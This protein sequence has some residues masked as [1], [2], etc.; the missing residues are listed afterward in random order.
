V[1]MVFAEHINPPP[2]RIAVGPIG[3]EA[4][5]PASRRGRAVCTGLSPFAH[6]G[7]AAHVTAHGVLEGRSAVHLLMQSNRQKRSSAIGSGAS[8]GGRGSSLQIHVWVGWAGLF[9]GLRWGAYS[10]PGRPPSPASSPEMRSLA[11][12]IGVRSVNALFSSGWLSRVWALRR[13]DAPPKTL[14][15]LT[16]IEPRV[17]LPIR[18]GSLGQPLGLLGRDRRRCWQ[19]PWPGQHRLSAVA[20][21]F[22]QRRQRRSPWSRRPSS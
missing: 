19:R 12:G 16:R 3:G 7:K 20:L 13:R 5:A 2:G 17:R 10:F 22:R 1:R 15:F 4:P 8:W 18:Q 6:I 21:I 9:G 11:G 14:F